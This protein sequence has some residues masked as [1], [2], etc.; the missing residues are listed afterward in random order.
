[1][2]QKG[3]S[4]TLV[5]ILALVIIAG[6][7]GYFVFF[8][9]QETTPTTTNTPTSNNSQN[10]QPTGTSVSG[11]PSLSADKKSVV[12]DGK[13]LLSIDSDTIFNW[14]KTESRLCDGYNLTST[15]DRKMFCENKTSFKSKIRFVSIVVSPDKMKIGFTIESDTLSPDKVAGIFFRS[16]NK[17]NLLTNYYLGNEFISFS[18]S[19]TNFVYQGGCFERMCGLFI[20]NS[21]T[22]AN[23]ASLNN[24]EF[25]DARG[26]NVTFVGWI[27]DNQVE[28][29][30]GT[31]LKRESF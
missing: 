14:F 30:L 2:N 6:V 20:K 31:E 26:Q 27:S 3:F 22:L 24:S 4:N 18:P 12:A 5:I 1:M 23:K 28:Y 9:K 16:T 10:T 11:T 8:Q 17:I 19:G 25:A 29:K 7:T 15:P 21:E 13:V